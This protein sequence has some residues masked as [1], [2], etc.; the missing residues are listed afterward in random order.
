MT[1]AGWQNST[2]AWSPDSSQIAFG[3]YDKDIDRYDIFLMKF[4]GTEL[5]RLT[6]RSGNNERP[7]WAPNGQLIVFESNRSKGRDVKDRPQIYVMHKDGSNQRLLPTGL[8]E[9][10][11]PQWGPTP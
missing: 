2:P 6:I 11:T 9:T 10:Q 8:Y 1:Y 5:E 7:S 3:G 4:D